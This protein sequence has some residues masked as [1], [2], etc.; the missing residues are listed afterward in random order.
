MH[1]DGLRHA[2]L[3]KGDVFTSDVIDTYLDHKRTNEVD[4]R[5]LRQHPYVFFL[6][7]D[8]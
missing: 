5:R 7:Y 2:L 6:Y 8:I 3:L 4:E 1:L